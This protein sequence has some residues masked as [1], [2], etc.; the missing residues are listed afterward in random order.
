M[1]MRFEILPLI[2]SYILLCQRVIYL[3]KIE[4]SIFKR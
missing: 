3:D 1:R 2:K 4:V